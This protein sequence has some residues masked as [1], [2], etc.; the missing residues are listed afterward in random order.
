MKMVLGEAQAAEEKS[1]KELASRC[2][3]RR[4]RQKLAFQNTGRTFVSPCKDTDCVYYT[5]PLN[6]Q[7]TKIPVLLQFPIM[8]QIKC[9]GTKC[10]VEKVSTCSNN[11]GN[12][13]PG[14]KRTNDELVR[15]F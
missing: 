15:Y 8:K 14:D 12:I 11:C 9:T 6:Y 7:P 2:R 5:K 13:S 4:K 10:L 3:H 1:P